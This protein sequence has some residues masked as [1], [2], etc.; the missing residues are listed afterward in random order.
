VVA[1]RT[2]IVDRRDRLGDVVG[3]DQGVIILQVV[4]EQLD[5]V[6][7]EETAEQ[8]VRMVAVAAA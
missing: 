8:T 5:R 2:T 6:L 3:E 7:T 4:W 1:E